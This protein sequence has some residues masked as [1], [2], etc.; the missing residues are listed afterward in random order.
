MF[1]RAVVKVCSPHNC[2]AHQ[3]GSC[4]AATGPPQPPCGCTPLDS[5]SIGKFNL[6]WFGR[7]VVCLSCASL[8][9]QYRKAKS[10]SHYLFGCIV[11]SQVCPSLCPCP[12]PKRSLKVMGLLGASSGIWCSGTVRKV[13]ICHCQVS[14]NK[15]HSCIKEHTQV[16]HPCLKPLKIAFTIKCKT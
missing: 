16:L 8:M 14:Q 15:V 5:F 11:Y 10:M 7:H 9:T 12:H 1:I 2:P 4:C 3:R 13:K 6:Y